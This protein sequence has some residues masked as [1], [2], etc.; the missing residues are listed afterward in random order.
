MCDAPGCTT[1]AYK[2][3]DFETKMLGVLPISFFKGC[4]V[5][6]CVMHSQISFEMKNGEEA[7]TAYCCMQCG[8]RFAQAAKYE[9]AARIALALVIAIALLLTV[10]A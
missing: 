7:V 4:G 5:K 8:P 9:Q 1:H 10:F 6:M 2:R 3:C